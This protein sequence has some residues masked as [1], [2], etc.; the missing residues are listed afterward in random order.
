MA[1]EFQNAEERAFL[2][3]EVNAIIKEGIESTI[4]NASYH[5]NKVAQWN[6]NIVELTLK[7]LVGLNKP[8]KYVVTCVIM[9]KT[10]A[11][12]HAASSCYWDNATDASTCF[13]WENKSMYTIVNV[14]GLAI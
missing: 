3:E 6:A 5:H 4:Q 14:Y 1:D 2:P 8:F 12:L 13:K 7:K 11:G 10:G 9:Q